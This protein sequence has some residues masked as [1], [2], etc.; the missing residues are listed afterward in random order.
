MIEFY[1]PASSGEWLAWASAL[2]TIGFGLLFLFAP[3]LSFRIIRIQT[4]PEH[5]E[6]LAEGRGTM[7]GFYLGLGVCCILFAQPMLWVALGAS[8][9][10]TAFG[11]LIS[12]MSDHGNTLYNWISIAMEIGLAALP[13]AFAFGFVI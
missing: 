8:W 1:W 10:F 13:L 3:R 9:G 6:A 7:A 11:R 5:P 4:H 2:I 12:M